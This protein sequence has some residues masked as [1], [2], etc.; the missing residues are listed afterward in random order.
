MSN[1]CFSPFRRTASRRP[2][3]T[4]SVR[5]LL[6]PTYPLLPLFTTTDFAQESRIGLKVAASS[7]NSHFCCLAL[8]PSSGRSMC[9]RPSLLYRA[10]I[11]VAT[12][13]FPLAIPRDT[14]STPGRPQVTISHDISGIL[15]V[16][17][18]DSIA[19]R[20]RFDCDS[21]AIRCEFSRKF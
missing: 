2:A 18:C 7:N 3:L 5:R 10:I 14:R 4:P 13:S 8:A 15:L 21:I 17:P 12:A 11:A 1:C 19:I 20:L 6:G 16:P 9:G